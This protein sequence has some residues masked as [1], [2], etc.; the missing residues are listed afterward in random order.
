MTRY[1]FEFDFTNY[2]NIP[3]GVILGCGVT[4]HEYED[5]IKILKEKVF[6]NK[7]LPQIKRVVENINLEEL[8]QNH[9]IP[10]MLPPSNRGIWFPLGYM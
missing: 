3:Y 8:D 9:V 6:A 1:W 2:I 7:D 10:N 5:V 4:G